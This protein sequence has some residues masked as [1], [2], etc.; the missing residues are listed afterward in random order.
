MKTVTFKLTDVGWV[1]EA[2]WAQS[3]QEIAVLSGPIERLLDV[4]ESLP[5]ESA[6]K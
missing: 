2:N 5:E 6:N 1:A 4:L 3:N